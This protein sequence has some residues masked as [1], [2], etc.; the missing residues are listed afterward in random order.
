M[1]T[2]QIDPALINK[3]IKS[4][5]IQDVVS[6][7]EGVDPELAAKVQQETSRLINTP[8]EEFE[9]FAQE[10]GL[11]TMGAI[12]SAMWEGLWAVSEPILPALFHYFGQLDS[13]KQLA[14]QKAFKELRPTPL[15]VGAAIEF[16]HK[17]PDEQDEAIE[18][19]KMQ[20]YSDERIRQYII[21]GRE[22]LT[23]NDIKELKHR[24]IF[25]EAEATKRLEYLGYYVEDAKTKQDSWTTLLDAGSIRDLYLRGIL[26]RENAAKQL[27]SLGYSDSSTDN[28]IKLF[29]FIPPVQDLVTMAVRE[30]FTPAVAERFGQYEDFPEEFASHAESLGI[31]REWAQRYWAAHWDLPSIQMGFEMLHR[32]VI[33]QTDVEMLLKAKDVMPFWRDKLTAI[34]YNPLTRVDV[35]RMHKIGVLDLEAVKRSYLDVGYNERNADLMTSFTIAYNTQNE[36]D[37]SKSEIINSYINKIISQEDVFEMLFDMGYDERETAMIVMLAEI[38][39]D[40]KI[41][42]SRI[43][44]IK[45]KYVKGVINLTQVNNDLN[46][47]NLTSGEIEVIVEDVEITKTSKAEELS[48]KDLKSAFKKQ[49]IKEPE[50]KSYL[51][52]MGY[53]KKEI[54]ILVKLV[55]QGG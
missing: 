36:R 32:G 34:S 12:W 27:Q 44:A 24:K 51:D 48:L 14:T 29:F 40:N 19:L 55:K 39:Q 18:N 8:L 42:N 50:F 41:K 45:N 23:E 38:K 3:L 28:I 25:T 30:V 22:A 53:G 49:I 11:T 16:L 6:Q 7:I 37:L 52:S 21:A 31:N 10:K 26:S 1:P 5:R 13:V 35:R 33:D 4:G 47:L 43:K 2:L 17:K 9:K 15:D 20:G 54:N 46:A